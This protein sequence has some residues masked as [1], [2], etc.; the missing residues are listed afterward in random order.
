MHDAKGPMLALWAQGMELRG[1]TC[2]TALAAYLAMPG[3]RVVPAGGPRAGATSSASCAAEA[4]AGGQASLFDDDQDDDAARTWR[5]AP[6]PSA[7]WPTRWRPSWSRA[8]GTHLMGDVEL[9]LVTVLAELERAGI[10]ADRDYF[11][12]LEAEFGAAVKQAVEA[13]HAAVGEQFNLGSPKQLQEILFVKLGAA[14]DQEDQDRL[15]HRRRPAG[16]A[17]HADRPRAAD[18]HVAPP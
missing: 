11:A 8:G 2:D 1:L 6:T 5:C 14:Q 9:P 17:G 4:E 10:A 3:Q 18:D 13:A 15:Q 16:L 12:G 7:S